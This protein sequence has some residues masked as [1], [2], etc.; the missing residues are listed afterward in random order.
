MLRH[1]TNKPRFAGCGRW[2]NGTH[3]G[4]VVVKVSAGLGAGVSGVQRCGSVWSCPVCAAVIRQERA[5]ELEEAI[6]AWLAKGHGIE[7]VTLTVPHRDTHALDATFNLVAQGWRVGV[8]GGRR[9]YE[10]RR[11]F[12]IAAWCRTVEVTHGANGWHPHIHALLFTMRPLDGRRRAILGEQLFER[13]SDWVARSGGGV[14][15]RAAFKIVG[16]SIGAGAYLAKLQDGSGRSL[17]QELTRADLKYA[18][19][20]GVSPFELIEAAFAGDDRALSLWHEWEHATAGRRCHTWSLGGRRLLGLGME[21][22]DQELVDEDQGGDVALVLPGWLW[23][24]VCAR[25]GGEA[26]LLAAV[27][28]GDAGDF[29]QLL[30]C[31]RDGP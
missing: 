13:W 18:G 16:G 2:L 22:S 26:D 17:S 5:Q 25:R 24:R 10:D 14:C 15:S 4:S 6:A 28:A 9:F 19:H 11:R 7:F 21:R 8:L 23:A 31:T 12:G 20:G 27:E 3:E 29:L 30:V 1:L